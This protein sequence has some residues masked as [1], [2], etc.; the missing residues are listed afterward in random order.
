MMKTANH[1]LACDD[2]LPSITKIGTNRFP[3]V[4][5]ILVQLQSQFR[6]LGRSSRASLAAVHTLNST[7]TMTKKLALSAALF[8]GA[9]TLFNSAT[10]ATH[11][12]TGG[13]ANE[14]WNNAANWSG[15]AP[16]AAEAA[17]VT[18][19]FPGGVVT[20]N[21][22]V[23]LKVDSL[24]FTGTGAI[25]HGAGGATLT[26]RGAGGT[27]VYS[28]S[29][30]SAVNTF[31]ATLP[32]TLSGSNYFFLN[33]GHN[34]EINSVISGSGSLTVNGD[35]F[36]YLSYGGTQANTASGKIS[37][38]GAIQLLLGKPAGVTAVAGPLEIANAS[39]RVRLKASN[40]IADSAP[41]TV[42]D[43]GTFDL[44]GFDDTVGPITL[45]LGQVSTGGGLL[46]LN[47]TITPVGPGNDISGRLSLGGVTRTLNITPDDSLTIRALISNG[48]AAAGIT[49]TG[50]GILVLYGTNTFTG[51]VTVSGGTLQLHNNYALGT[52]AGGLTVSTNCT[53]RLMGVSIGAETLAL[54]GELDVYNTNT[55]AGAVT[56]GNLSVI[57]LNGTGSQLTVSQAIS[58][59]A[60]KKN[61]TG[62]LV[63]S[64]AQANTF[65]GG[66]TVGGGFVRLNKAGVVA[67]PGPLQIST[68]TVQLLQAN[69]IADATAVIV[70]PGGMLNL[71]NFA[72]T[73]GSLTGNGNVSVGV[74]TL[75]TGGNNASTSFGGVIYGIGFAPLIKNGSGTFTLNGTNAC[76][77]TSSVNGGTLVVNGELPGLV[78]LNASA[79]LSGIGKVGNLTSTSGKV[80]P[81]NS[82]GK[83]M[84][85]NLA[86]NNAAGSVTFE[87]A[88]TTPGSGH[89]QIVVNG[90]VTLNNATL[91]VLPA[92][93]GGLGKQYVLIANDG[94]DAVNGTFNGLAEG[95]TVTAGLLQYAISYMGGTG[96]DVVL[97]QA[98]VP[99][100]PQITQLTKLPNGQMQITGTGI[101]GATYFIEA[102]TDLGT[103]NWSDIGGVATDWNGVI[104]FTDPNAV[105]FPQRFYRFRMQ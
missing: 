98:A 12:W 11:T 4:G 8:L 77:G 48:A 97:T 82:I 94:V 25:L 93:A 90:S 71:N 19:I 89:D 81:G 72:E 73:I 85:G 65:T 39:A 79:S 32:V 23:G 14:L 87:I 91:S 76:T 53:L 10:A 41:I 27:N 17:P 30:A 95:A 52:T 84:T 102:T 88:G 62:T 26:L 6:S 75:T 16:T 104:K 58:G 21:N 43:M 36:G 68:G 96:N 45:H 56:V 59:G 18:L 51:P 86:L 105:N 69:Q 9:F 61:G 64:G 74:G 22:I 3:C 46:T 44:A 20:T 47:G 63:F 54:N 50:G 33:N 70:Q 34:I 2:Q 99:P 60:L 38:I 7:P 49:K 55:W 57:D 100:S 83:L 1:F 80:F 28:A 78:T 13:G 29:G 101:V 5:L 35:G 24:R 37:L 66:L 67:V 15:G 92:G 31:A 40:Q 103:P 42:N